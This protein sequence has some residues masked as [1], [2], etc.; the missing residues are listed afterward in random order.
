MFSP[1]EI[2]DQFLTVKKWLKAVLSKG[3][4]SPARRIFTLIVF[5]LVFILGYQ[6]LLRSLLFEVDKQNEKIKQDQDWVI[7]ANGYD[8]TARFAKLCISSTQNGSPNA[9]WYC[10]RAK[11]LYKNNSRKISLNQREEVLEREA[12]GAMVADMESELAGI[13]LDKLNQTL[14]ASDRL[15]L[16]LSKAGIYI[17]LSLLIFGML[18]FI[19]GLYFYRQDDEANLSKD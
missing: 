6:L 4:S 11:R 14:P 10:E 3:R 5:G 8:L 13:K 1:K 15:E 12:Y 2:D 9:L 16:V 19:Y 18:L 7:E 17:T